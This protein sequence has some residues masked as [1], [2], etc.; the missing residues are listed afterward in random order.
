MCFIFNLNFLLLWYPCKLSY[1]IIVTTENMYVFFT[2]VCV[3]IW[4]DSFSKCIQH[5]HGTYCLPATVLS[6][7]VILRHQR[8]TQILFHPLYRWEKWGS[9]KVWELPTIT[10]PLSGK[11]DFQA[12]LQGSAVWASDHVWCLT[13]SSLPSLNHPSSLPS[14]F[15]IPTRQEVFHPGQ[16]KATPP[17]WQ[18]SRLSE[19]FP[20]FTRPNQSR[21]CSSNIKIFLCWC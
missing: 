7:N 3:C 12:W 19:A 18:T 17:P 21:R 13:G 15:S 10:Q 5:L 8:H 14:C 6:L 2:S 4:R 16:E 1:V 11:A 20:G 9:A